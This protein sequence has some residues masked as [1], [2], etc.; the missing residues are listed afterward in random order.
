[1]SIQ[2]SIR[3]SWKAYSRETTP[4]GL[5]SK[6][7]S[8]NGQGR[9]ASPASSVSGSN[10][11]SPSNHLFSRPTPIVRKLFSGSSPLSGAGNGEF[12]NLFM[13]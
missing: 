11:M 9:S 2:V 8:S 13:E 5:R 6:S 10:L 7:V 4:D 3:S 12:L 1:L